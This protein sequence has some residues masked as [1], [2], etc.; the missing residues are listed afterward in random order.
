ML[1]RVVE[2]KRAIQM[3]STFREVTGEQQG[4]A[5]EAMADHERNSRPLLLGECQEPR[6]DVATGIAVERK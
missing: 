5:H 4:R 6:R 1:D 3:R 2:R